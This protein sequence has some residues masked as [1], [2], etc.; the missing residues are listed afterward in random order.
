MHAR[1][2]NLLGASGSGATTAGK[3]LAAALSVPHFDSD[4]YYH[5]PTDPPFQRQRQ[6]HERHDMIVADLSR[7]PSWVLSGGVVGWEPSPRLDFTLIVFLWVPA[8]TRIERLRRREQ[9]RFGRRVL[10]GGDMHTNHEGFIDW[11]SRYD[12]GD[13]EGKTLARHEAYLA[14]QTC[15]VLQI[16]GSATTGQVVQTVLDSLRHES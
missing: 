8:A 13:I 3:A 16:R 12:Q 9:E 1:R 10:E 5:E 15:P 14:D 11:A 6:P 2:I 4:D 7:T